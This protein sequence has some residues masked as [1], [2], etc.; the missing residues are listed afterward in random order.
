MNGERNLVDAR[1][2]EQRR[3]RDI[4]LERVIDKPSA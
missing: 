3:S 2:A 1:P 4:V